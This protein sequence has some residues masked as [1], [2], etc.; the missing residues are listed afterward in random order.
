MSEFEMVLKRQWEMLRDLT[1]TET[2]L[3]LTDMAKKFGVSEKTIKR[4]LLSLRAV[5]GK[6]KSVNEAHGRK[7][8]RYDTQSLTFDEILGYDELFALSLCK[9]FFNALKGTK[10]GTDGFNAIEK[11]GKTLRPKTKEL[12][13]R[14]APVCR[15][16]GPYEDR[17]LKVI[18]AIYTA[19]RNN[20]VLT[21]KY[22]SLSSKE[23]K[24]YE[25]CPYKFHYQNNSVY[26]VGLCCSDRKVKFWKIN[27]LHDAE[28]L[29]SRKFRIPEKFDTGDYLTNGFTLY[30][31]SDDAE[32]TLVTL[33]LTGYAAR[34]FEEDK[35]CKILKLTRQKA[36]AII[37]ELET[38]VN[39]TFYNAILN[40][41]E[42]AEILAPES[43]RRHMT[44]KLDQMRASY[45][46]SKAAPTPLEYY[47]RLDEF[48][49]EEDP[50]SYQEGGEE[51][52]FLIDNAQPVDYE[53]EINDLAY[54]GEKRRRGRPR[55]HPIQI[56]RPKRKRGRP[57][58]VRPEDEQA[59]PEVAGLTPTPA[60]KE[61]PEADEEKRQRGVRPLTGK[62]MAK[63]LSKQ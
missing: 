50:D 32:S 57:R 2:G 28:I 47:R 30:A 17:L 45:L 22:R 40:Y 46:S 24:T 38:E 20:Y 7:R 14:F 16:L 52:Q 54:V 29:A 56:D 6:W 5:F 43:M 35:P 55:K 10:V 37:V 53:V 34:L 49:E 44:E 9:T 58:K 11:I 19:M 1:T 8:Y 31:K 33:R 4:D 61:A 51:D 13:E 27:R 62:E 23:Y 48:T 36:G 21:I 39:E 25:I 26:L 3:T 15:R 60:S 42:N 41:G 59:L 12:A 63:K 18:D